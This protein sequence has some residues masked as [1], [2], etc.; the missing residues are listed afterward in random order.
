VLRGRIT[1][2]YI[3][4]NGSP[5]AGTTDVTIATLGTSPSPPANTI[6]TLTNAATDGWFYPRH[7]IHDEAGGGVTYDGTNEVYEAPTIFDKV[8]VTIA[9]ANDADSADVWLLLE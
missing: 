4:Y 1:A 9:G 3:K 7:Q 5:P 6:L 8:K 2:V